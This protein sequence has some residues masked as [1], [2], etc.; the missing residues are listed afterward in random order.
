[1]VHFYHANILNNKVRLV[2]TVSQLYQLLSKDSSEV[3]A[4]PSTTVFKYVDSLALIEDNEQYSQPI[5]MI[6]YLNSKTFLQDKCLVNIQFNERETHLTNLPLRGNISKFHIG[7]QLLTLVIRS[8]TRR[9]AATVFSI[10]LIYWTEVQ[11]CAF[12]FSMRFCSQ[13]Q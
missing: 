5:D 2:V 3:K 6:K 12:I 8:K 10:H 13:K 1:M 7:I 9:T 11:T 4:Y